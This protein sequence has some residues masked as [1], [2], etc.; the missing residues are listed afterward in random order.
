VVF[1]RTGNTTQG[2]VFL[3]NDAGRLRIVVADNNGNQEYGPQ[4]GRI[5]FAK[6]PAGADNPPSNQAGNPANGTTI[7][8][9][10]NQAWTATGITVRRG[11]VLTFSS[12][13]EIHLSGDANDVASVDGARSGRVAPSAPLPRSPA[14]AL[15]GRIGTGQPFGIGSQQRITAPA[16]GQLFLG[17]N[18]DGFNDNQG[19][20]Q[21]TIS[22]Q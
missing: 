17:V 1:L 16:T 21:V 22:R 6:A 3:S 2:R 11:Q 18:D 12:S 15:I 14:G 13:G 8:V 5:Y 7:T 20:F 9:N 19:S 10:A 4:V